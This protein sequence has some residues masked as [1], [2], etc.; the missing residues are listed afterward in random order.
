MEESRHQC[1]SGDR[2]SMLPVMRQRRALARG[3]PIA[4]LPILMR[5]RLSKCKWHRFG[6]RIALVRSTRRIPTSPCFCELASCKTLGITSRACACS[7]TKNCAGGSINVQKRSIDTLPRG[8]SSANGHSVT[9]PHTWPRH[10]GPSPPAKAAKEAAS[11]AWRRAGPGATGIR[12]GA[13]PSSS[14]TARTR[15]TRARRRRE[16]IEGLHARVVLTG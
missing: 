1:S 6:P 8:C 5:A 12:R 11:R 4:M 7:S 10:G 9:V 3:Q 16:S 2:D 14:S 13:N 15:T